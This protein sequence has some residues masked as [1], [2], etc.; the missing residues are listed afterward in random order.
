MTTAVSLLAVIEQMNLG[1]GWLL[2]VSV[3]IPSLIAASGLIYV[4]LSHS[5]F[6]HPDFL[7]VLLHAEECFV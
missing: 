5:L 4:R 3:R 6:M 7:K 2:S 1:S